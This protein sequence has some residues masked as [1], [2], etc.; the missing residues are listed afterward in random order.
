[1][2]VLIVEDFQ[3]LR[4]SLEQGLREAGFA[5]DSFADGRDAL[6]RAMSGEYDVILL[7]LMLPGL[8][9]LSLLRGLR[10]KGIGSAVL[11]LT[12][13]DATE[14]CVKAL[15]AGADDYLTK[16]FAFAELMAR[17][18]ALV[19][20]NY[21]RHSPV[22]KVADL[23]MDTAARLVRRGG[24]EI[25]LTAREY[26]LLEL[27]AMREGEVASRREIWDHMYDLHGSAQSN[28]VD[29]YVGL[30]RRKIDVEGLPRLIH[31][32]RGLGYV[33][34]AAASAADEGDHSSDEPGE[35]PRRCDR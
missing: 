11:V 16:P 9:G 12:A 14:D 33:L 7:D 19:R 5:A 34:R 30:L 13:R 6:L 3:P 32:R 24:K 23:E 10:Q 18:R 31:T 2:R 8:D 29:V 1:M 35:E 22:V 21:A 20:R 28:V 17:V 26:A 27:L 15:D 25:A 4:Q